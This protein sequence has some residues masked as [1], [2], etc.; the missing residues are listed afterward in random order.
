MYACLSFCQRRMDA[1]HWEISCLIRSWKK[2][3]IKKKNEGRRMRRSAHECGV[4]TIIH[5]TRNSSLL[6]E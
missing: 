2:K 1:M 4:G 6:V 5:R 3:V